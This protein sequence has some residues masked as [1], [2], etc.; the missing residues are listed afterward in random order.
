MTEMKTSGGT[1][2]TFSKN[3]NGLTKSMLFAAIAVIVTMAT[4]WFT[5]GMNTVSRDEMEKYVLE[6]SSSLNQTVME[7]KTAVKELNNTSTELDAQVRLLKMD[8]QHLRDG[9]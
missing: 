9:H 6:H 5:M 1:K 3:N 2:Y 8:I 4:A 7:L